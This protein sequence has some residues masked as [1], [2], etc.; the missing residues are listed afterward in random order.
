MSLFSI[1]I[2]LD[3]AARLDDLL[4]SAGRC[5]LPIILPFFAPVIF[6]KLLG[7]VLLTTGLARLSETH[8]QRHVLH[9][10]SMHT[11]LARPMTEAP[12]EVASQVS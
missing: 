12:L 2:V 10:E 1:V 4:R 8:L 7:L 5:R 3:Q 6:G 9:A 11:V